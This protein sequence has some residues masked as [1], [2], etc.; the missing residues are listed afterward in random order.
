[1][2]KTVTDLNWRSALGSDHHRCNSASRLFLLSQPSSSSSS[3]IH[4]QAGH[5]VV[6]VYLADLQ[7]CHLS[8]CIAVLDGK[9]GC[10]MF[11]KAIVQKRFLECLQFRQH[12]YSKTQIGKPQLAVSPSRLRH[13]F[14]ITWGYTKGSVQS[15]IKNLPPDEWWNSVQ[16][17]QLQKLW[18]IWVLLQR[19]V[20]IICKRS[21]T[22]IW[23][24]YF[25]V[26]E[27]F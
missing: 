16:A 6:V 13:I 12:Q 11:L 15:I 26:L 1:M 20:K 14:Q 4:T 27:S 23:P 25:T 19:G 5:E 21:Q 3:S 9:D 22:I 17:D 24:W 18:I 2:K 10:T 8:H 7:F